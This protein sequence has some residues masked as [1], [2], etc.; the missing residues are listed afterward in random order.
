ML[1]IS[2]GPLS[3]PFDRFLILISFAIAMLVGYIASRKNNEP[4]S[5][6]VDGQ[7]A[8][9]FIIA[10]IVAR[11]IFVVQ[12][13]QE[14]SANWLSIIDIRD[15]GFNVW[16]GLI[17]LLLM[18]V[19]YSWREPKT[20][21]PFLGGAVAGFLVWSLVSVG[22]WA[23]EDTSQRLPKL[24]V[25]ELNGQSIELNDIEAGI[26]R[27]INLWATWC[28][29]CRREMPVLQQAQQENPDTGII[30]VNQG[31]H[32]AVV[33]QYL[34]KESLNLNNTVMDTKAMLGQLVGSRALPTTLFIN[35]KGELVDAHL[36]E[37]SRAS[38][39]AKLERLKQSEIKNQ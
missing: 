19:W 6:S 8:S 34:Q 22:L 15:G 2:I 9:V 30:F 11:L 39:A 20:R 4:E 16:A 26:P 5:K 13:W 12:Y 10:M 25:S 7:L 36:G 3:L 31:E 17:A 37:L 27:V 1:T 14:Y 33:E 38:L 28:P 32:P 18:I 35:A 21:K 24:V 23:I 29:P